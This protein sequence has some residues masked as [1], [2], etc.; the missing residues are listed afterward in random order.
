MSKS[1]VY[2][3]QEYLSAAFHSCL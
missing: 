2:Q 1:V 3:G